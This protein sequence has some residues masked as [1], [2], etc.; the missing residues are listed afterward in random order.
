[1]GRNGYPQ[2]H[3]RSDKD[4][5]KN[6]DFKTTRVSINVTQNRQADHR[7]HRDETAQK[8]E[9]KTRRLEEDDPRAR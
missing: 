6:R 8:E 2:E 5:N 1:V 4:V 9:R 7:R 3:D